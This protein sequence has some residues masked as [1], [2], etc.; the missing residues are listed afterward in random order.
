[1]IK[2]KISPNDTICFVIR[3]DLQIF[4][5]KKIYP[6]ISPINNNEISYSTVNFYWVPVSNAQEYEVQVSRTNNFDESLQSEIVTLPGAEF[7]LEPGTWYWR[8]RTRSKYGI[9]GEFDKKDEPEYYTFTIKTQS[10]T[11]N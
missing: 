4:D 1:M 7:N 2:Q 5:I 3:R 11:A 8:V 9:W 6:K 10:L